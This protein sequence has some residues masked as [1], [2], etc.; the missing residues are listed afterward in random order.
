MSKNNIENIFI[1]ISGELK[2]KAILYNVIPH[3][4][5]RERK[6]VKN[7]ADIIIPEF[8]EMFS[9]YTEEHPLPKRVEW[10]QFIHVIARMFNTVNDKRASGVLFGIIQRYY[11]QNSEFYRNLYKIIYLHKMKDYE[12]Y[13][14]LK[15]NMIK[16]KSSIHNFEVYKY[17]YRYSLNIYIY[18]EYEKH[19]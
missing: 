12:R 18:I 3:G 14:E 4:S 10:M 16:L 15:E 11:S 1:R 17:V 5:A 2:R 19:K 8:E 13:I 7:Y 6:V 9:K